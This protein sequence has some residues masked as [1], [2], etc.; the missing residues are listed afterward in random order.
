VTKISP[1]FELVIDSTSTRVGAGNNAGVWLRRRGGSA[2]V[3]GGTPGMNFGLKSPYSCLQAFEYSVFAHEV[4]P[5]PS[6]EQIPL[7]IA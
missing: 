4:Q 6:F 7:A 2:V 1:G 5:I 3:V